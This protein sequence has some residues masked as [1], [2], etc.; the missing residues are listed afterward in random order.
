M[1]SFIKR[2]PP[3][4][5]GRPPGADKKVQ[6]PL[7]TQSLQWIMKGVVGLRWVSFSNTSNC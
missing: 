7:L 3:E 2:A 1:C 6:L 4:F 5:K